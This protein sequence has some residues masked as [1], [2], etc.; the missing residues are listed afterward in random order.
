MTNSEDIEKIRSYLSFQASGQI[1][2]Y[3]VARANEL[4]TVAIETN[5]DAAAARAGRSVTLTSF[6]PITYGTVSISFYGQTQPVFKQPGTTKGENV[7]ASATTNQ[8]FLEDLNKLK[9]GEISQPLIAGQYVM[10]ASLSDSK[11]L[12]EEELGYQRPSIYLPI[13]A[14]QYYQIDYFTS[15]M[16][17]KDLKDNFDNVVLRLLRTENDL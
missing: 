5:L 10:V 3:F 11:K 13:L 2:D 12:S 17:S 4:R 8:S 15:I 7:L 14:Q 6:F 9:K 1:E 16:D